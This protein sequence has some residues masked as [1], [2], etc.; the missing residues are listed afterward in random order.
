[1]LIIAVPSR[2]KFRRISTKPGGTLNSFAN[3]EDPPIWLVLPCW[4]IPVCRMPKCSG[5]DPK[6]EEMKCNGWGY[7]VTTTYYTVYTGLPSSTYLKLLR[8]IH[9]SIHVG[10]L[11]SPLPSSAERCSWNKWGCKNWGRKRFEASHRNRAGEYC[12]RINAKMIKN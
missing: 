11:L 1:M 7:C 8:P 3:F 6:G 10:G 2:V 12:V 4:S 5:I 9:S